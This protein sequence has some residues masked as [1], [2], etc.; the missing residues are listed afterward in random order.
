[1]QALKVDAKNELRW[2]LAEINNRLNK[3]LKEAVAAGPRLS[4]DLKINDLRA[5][6]D[7]LLSQLQNI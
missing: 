7:V 4:T 3:L 1:M 6:R 5:R 2:E